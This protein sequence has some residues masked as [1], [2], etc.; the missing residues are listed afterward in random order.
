L[1][2]SAAGHSGTLFPFFPQTDPG[3]ERMGGSRE[4][5]P[6][7]ADSLLCHRGSPIPS[8]C[9]QARKPEATKP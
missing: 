3:A 8:F 5:K 7:I 9:C 1:D 4:A 6:A 2:T